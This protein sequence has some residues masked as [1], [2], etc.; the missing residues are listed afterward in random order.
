MPAIRTCDSCNQEGH[1][2][3]TSR[4][5]PNNCRA[6]TCTSCGNIDHRYTTHRDCPNNVANR[7]F[8]MLSLSYIVSKSNDNLS[9]YQKYIKSGCFWKVVDDIKSDIKLIE[10]KKNLETISKEIACRKG[11]DEGLEVILTQQLKLIKERRRLSSE[12]QM[13]QSFSCL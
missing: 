2:R 12:Y 6:A 9:I 13:L 3:I 1:S 8:F 5:C 10:E 11:V 7:M 4:L